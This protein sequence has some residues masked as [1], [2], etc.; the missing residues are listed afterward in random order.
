MNSGLGFSG[1]VAKAFLT[2][3]ITPLLALIGLLLGV[4]AVVVTGELL[5]ILFS[6]ASVNPLQDFLKQLS[7]ISLMVQWIGLTFSQNL[8]PSQNH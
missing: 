2:T 6:L 5:A 4:F 8:D 1:K 7:L 3:Q